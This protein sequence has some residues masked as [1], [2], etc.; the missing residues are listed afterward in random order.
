[1]LSAKARLN[2]RPC[3]NIFGTNSLPMGGPLAL[4]A[5]LGGATEFQKKTTPRFHCQAHLVNMYQFRTLADIADAIQKAWVDPLTVVRFQ[6]WVHSEMAPDTELYRAEK[7]AVRAAWLQGYGDG[8]HDDLC[9]IPLC[10][11]DKVCSEDWLAQYNRDVQFAFSRMQE[12]Y[13]QKTKKTYATA[14]LY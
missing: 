6:E 2:A 9:K 10:M 14:V 11:Q 13:H 12:P 3:Q 7:A 8:K 5:T 4:A 1:M